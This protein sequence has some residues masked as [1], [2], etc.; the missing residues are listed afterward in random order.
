MPIVERLLCYISMCVT[1]V[2]SYGFSGLAFAGSPFSLSLSL[3]PSLSRFL[4]CELPSCGK[5]CCVCFGRSNELHGDSQAR[6]PPPPRH[7]ATPRPPSPRPHRFTTVFDRSLLSLF[8]GLS[9]CPFSATA[10]VLRDWEGGAA[11]QRRRDGE[12]WRDGGVQ[13]CL[14]GQ[15]GFFLI[16]YRIILL[17]LFPSSKL[18]HLFRLT[19]S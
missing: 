1:S 19:S 3:S 10:A 17:M 5:T 6:P 15:G 16:L 9:L 13:H 8:F 18:A 12:G 7:P 14:Y 4:W 11:G 2:V